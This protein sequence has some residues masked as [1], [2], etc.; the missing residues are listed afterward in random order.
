M[1]IRSR[2]IEVPEED[3]A[4]FEIVMLARVQDLVPRASGLA[5]N[6]ESPRH[7][8]QFHKLRP[9]AYDGDD[10]HHNEDGRAGL[11]VKA[12]DLLADVFQVGPF[13]PLVYGKG[14]RVR[15]ELL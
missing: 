6:G 11:A 14:Q 5:E 12:P 2:D 10:P 9:R 7:H 8:R 3:L 1:K 15:R 13:E 4:H